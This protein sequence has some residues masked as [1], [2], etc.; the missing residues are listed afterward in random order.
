MQDKV[1]A[2][3]TRPCDIGDG[4]RREPVMRGGGRYGGGG[5]WR[6]HD[7]KYTLLVGG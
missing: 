6:D 4:Q 7:W 5:G 3:R 2:E 1:K